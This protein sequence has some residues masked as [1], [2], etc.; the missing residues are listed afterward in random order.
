[1]TEAAPESLPRER[2]PRRGDVLDVAVEGYAAGGGLYARH[3]DDSGDYRVELRRGVPGER[4]RV[5]VLRRRGHDLRARC[6]ELLEPSPHAVEAACAHLPECGGCSHQELAYERQLE[7]K[8]DVARRILQ[9]AGLLIGPGDPGVEPCIGCESPWRYRNKMDFTFSARR[10]VQ[11]SEPE[12]SERDFALGLHPAGHFDKVVDVHAC[13]ITFEECGGLL[14]D[15]RALAREQGLDAWDV[16]RQAGLMR[17][18]VLRKSQARGELLVNLVTAEEA[19]ERVVPWV[20]ALRAR[21]PEIT[22]LVQGVHDGLAKVALGQREIVHF[23]PGSIVEELGG[24]AFRISSRSF[25]QTNTS[26]AER[27]LVLAL[28]A[29]GLRGSELVFDLYCGAGAFSLSLAARAA[30]VV[31]IEVVE[32]AV[33]DARD[34]A[35]RNGVENVEFIAGDVA[36]VLAE[37]RLP[38]PD[39]V[40]VDPPRSGLHSRVV[41]AIAECGA[42]RLVYVS[43]NLKSAARDCLAFAGSGLRLTRVQP[44]DLFPHTPHLETVLTL[45][46]AP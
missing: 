19:P 11:A 46:R 1:M 10:Y 28:E 18:L 44:V 2:K 39:L 15:A 30:R 32:E 3:T 43:C 4:R 17:H 42:P 31:G 24:H 34:N 37:G 33:A 21:H 12:D 7:Q 35:R 5:Q 45:E 26:Q 29:A 8:R 36:A 20:R 13:Q 23:G 14:R 40:L 41:Q 25:F 27:L 38:A 6:G 22:T 16:R 9:G